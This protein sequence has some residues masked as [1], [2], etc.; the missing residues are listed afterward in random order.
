[1]RLLLICTH[2]GTILIFRYMFYLFSCC[3]NSRIIQYMNFKF[4]ALL[5]Y[6]KTTKCVKFQGVWCT[7][8]RVGV[9]RISPIP[10]GFHLKCLLTAFEC[11]KWLPWAVAV[12]IMFLLDQTGNLKIRWNLVLYARLFKSPR[13]DSSNTTS[14]WL[15]SSVSELANFSSYFPLQL[16]FNGSNNFGTMKICS[17][18]G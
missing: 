17:R 4:Q 5:S 16:N 6:T 1:M 12:K 11:R 13:F 14:L 8:V 15:S 10:R 9:F 2:L 18:Q 3:Y 7:G